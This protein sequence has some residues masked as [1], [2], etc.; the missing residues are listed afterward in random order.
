VD[1]ATCRATMCGFYACV[2]CDVNKMYLIKQFLSCNFLCEQLQKLVS[3]SFLLTIY[4]KCFAGS[5]V[6]SNMDLFELIT[7]NENLEYEVSRDETINSCHLV[8]GLILV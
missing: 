6:W 4:L 1:M 5:F 2:L 7:V 8:F 3:Q